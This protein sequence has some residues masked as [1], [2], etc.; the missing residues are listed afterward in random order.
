MSD[1]RP[2]A[3]V[4]LAGTED[5]PA[6][7][8]S[9]IAVALDEIAPVD[10]SC[11]AA[12]WS[13]APTIG[14]TALQRFGAM[15]AEREPCVLVLDD[16]HELA[17]RDVRD[18]LAVLVSE[19]A[20]G[21][22]IVL[23]GRTAVPLPLGRLRASRRLVEV[24]SAELAFDTSEAASL[25]GALGL[26]VLPDENAVLVQQT[27]GWP[28]AVYLAALAHSTSRGDVRSTIGDF[29]GDHRYLIDYLGE[30]LL[31]R[32]EPAVISF[33]MEASCLERLSGPVCDGVLQRTDSADLL[34]VL[35]RQTL[36]VIPLD[37]R[38]EWYRF[39]HVMAEFLQAELGRRDPARRLDIHRRA[40]EW[41]DAHQDPDGAVTHAIRSGDMTRAQSMVL[42]W[43][44]TVATV[45]RQTPVTER[46]VGLF[47]AH[48]LEQ[49]PLLMVMA[50]WA[51]FARGD[52]RSAVRWLTRATGALPDRYPPDVLGQVP[53]VALAMAMSIIA[54]LSPAEMAIEATYVHQHVGLG[55]GHPLACLGLGAAAFL[56]GDDVE[57]AQRLREGAETTLSRPL[58]V[59]NCL[60]HLA[61]IDIDHDRWSEAEIHARSARALIGEASCFVSTTLVLAA[62]VLVETRAGRGDDVDADRRLCRQHLSG[63]VGAAP[64]LNIQARVALAH[65]ALLRSD[66]IEAATLVDETQ[67]I[68][69]ALHG[70][71]GASKQLAGIKQ[72]LTPVRDRSARYGPSSLT[73]AELRVLRLLPTHLS[74]AEIGDRLF[75]SRNT[76]KSQAVTI[77]R[78]LGTSTRSG[79]V[80][81][82]VSAG[83]LD[84][85]PLSASPS[86]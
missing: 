73:T 20:P 84:N 36:L 45:G 69:A 62:Y 2:T 10:P 56:T 78:K 64:W 9:Y 49:R 22:S 30:E 61:M 37:D 72:Q 41:C 18:V 63:L 34:D 12:L 51:N 5:D 58:V 42:R 28:V 65:D 77:Y 53:E 80:A 74:M 52:S 40:S 19:L 60:A 3:W 13:S 83:L 79:A 23:A 29:T 21:S 44:P 59:A 35:Q 76:V 67:R 50:A 43:Y 33:L 31:A 38:Q 15:L 82:A 47:P 81:I 75:V 1:P 48:E 27:E 68:V 86:R 54:P 46:W 70:A 39:H 32:L 4:S 14:S 8:L 66:N 7:L 26:D 85:P 25:F 57:A 71:I 55:D 16:V 11:V 6:S 24:G 17:S